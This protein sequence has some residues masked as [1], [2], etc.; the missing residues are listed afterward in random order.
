MSPRIDLLRIWA[1]PA[2][3]S[4][5][6]VLW[7]MAEVGRY[8]PAA[9]AGMLV[10]FAVAIAISRVW[11]VV[12]ISIVTLILALQVLTVLPPPESTTWPVYLAAPLVAFFVALEAGTRTRWTTLALGAPVSI[13]VAYLMVNPLSGQVARWTSWTGQADTSRVVNGSFVAIALVGP[14]LYAGAWAIGYALR[15][16]MRELRALLV[17]RSTTAQLDD[18]ATEL[19][20]TRERDRI[21]RDVHDVLAHSLAVVV[22][23]ADGARFASSTRPEVATVALGAIADA[24]RSAL[25]DVRTLIEGLREEPGDQPQPGLADIPALLEQMSGAGMRADAQH[26]GAAKAMT[27]AQQL[28]VFRIVQESLTNGLRH[29]GRSATMR[30]SFDWRGPGLALTV[31]SSGDE[32]PVLP[33]IAGGHGIRGM[34]DRARLVGGWLTAGETDDPPGFIVTAYIPTAPEPAAVTTALELTP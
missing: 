1:A 16:S 5:F 20:M 6:L 26:F 33:G 15:V 32:H 30:L 29:A 24:A 2:V 9:S 19:T 23:Q 28:A 3:G 31:T 34:K 7:I 4:A 14:G 17:L 13:A 10:A 25:V 11:P 21:A 12:S 8:H 27:P 18:V 22:A